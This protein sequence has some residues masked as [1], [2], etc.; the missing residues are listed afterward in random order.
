MTARVY[1]ITPAP[2]DPAVVRAI[3]RA[4]DQL[5]DDELAPPAEWARTAAEEQ[6]DCGV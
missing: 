6:L 5:A 2:D 3:A 4:L 1:E